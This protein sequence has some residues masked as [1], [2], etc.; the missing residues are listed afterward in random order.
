MFKT[1]CWSGSSMHGAQSFSCISRLQSFHAGCVAPSGRAMIEVCAMHKIDVNIRNVSSALTWKLFLSDLLKMIQ[2][3]TKRIVQIHIFLIICIGFI[4]VYKHCLHALVGCGI[5]CVRHCSSMLQ[6]EAW[7][8]SSTVINCLIVKTKRKN[9]NSWSQCTIFSFMETVC[10]TLWTVIC[11]LKERTWMYLV[12]LQ[13][14]IARLAW[15]WH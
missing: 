1:L 5:L 11:W 15:W 3:R 2:Y 7:C 14:T 4:F 10:W 12:Y 6:H 8:S 13:L 9:E